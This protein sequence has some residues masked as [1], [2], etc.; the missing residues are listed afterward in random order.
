MTWKAGDTPGVHWLTT[1]SGPAGMVRKTGKVW[2]CWL[3]VPGGKPQELPRH[4][5]TLGEARKLVERS[6]QNR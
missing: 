3:I 1:D 6:H 2:T 4:P 5:R